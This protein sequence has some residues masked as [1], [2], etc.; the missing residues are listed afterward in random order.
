MNCLYNEFIKDENR[1]INIP[2]IA[3][4]Y[5]RAPWWQYDACKSSPE[6]G[7]PSAEVLG[8]LI[9]MAKVICLK[10]ESISYWKKRVFD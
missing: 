8:Y 7:N 6:W 2:E 5:P 3:N 4:E 9:N 10:V 1:W